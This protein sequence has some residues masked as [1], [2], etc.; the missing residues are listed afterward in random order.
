V[1][2]GAMGGEWTDGGCIGEV[3]EGK[4]V[5][6]RVVVVPPVPCGVPGIMGRVL[7]GVDMVGALVHQGMGERMGKNR[8][9]EG[10]ELS[11]YMTKV[12][13]Q[14]HSRSCLS[15]FYG[16]LSTPRD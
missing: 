3:T 13:V 7:R 10:E 9:W 1:S 4:V 14:C 16:V 5:D 8:I 15:L 12:R 2:R 11:N 6:G